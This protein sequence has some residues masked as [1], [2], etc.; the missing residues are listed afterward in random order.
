MSET[1]DDV[2]ETYWE[3]YLSDLRALS[4]DNDGVRLTPSYKD[5]LVWLSDNDIDTEDAE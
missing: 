4:E 2:T 1:R 3:E 5:Y